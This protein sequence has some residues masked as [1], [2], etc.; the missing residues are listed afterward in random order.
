M[1]ATSWAQMEQF[2]SAIQINLLHWAVQRWGRAIVCFYFLTLLSTKVMNQCSLKDLSS[3]HS[4]IPVYKTPTPSPSFCVHTTLWNIH[5]HKTDFSTTSD[6]PCAVHSLCI[7]IQSGG[8]RFWI[9]MYG[10][11]WMEI[12]TTKLQNHPEA[13]REMTIKQHIPFHK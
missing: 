8:V 2:R 3:P 12:T 9:C 7:K 1:L 13:V 10:R 4:K 6:T 5:T 11:N